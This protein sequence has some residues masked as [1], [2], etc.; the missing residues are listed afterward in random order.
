MDRGAWQ[1]LDM[2]K[3]THTH[4]HTHAIYKYLMG[5]VLVETRTKEFK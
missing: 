5:K 4:T 2:T 3:H 1:E